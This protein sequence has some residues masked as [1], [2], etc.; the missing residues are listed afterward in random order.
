[1]PLCC[2]ISRIHSTTPAISAAMA[3]C[4]RTSSWINITGLRL[5]IR[6]NISLLKKKIN[7]IWKAGIGYTFFV[8]WS[9]SFETFI[10]IKDKDKKTI[11][12]NH[13]YK[14]T[15]LIQLDAY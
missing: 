13:W 11:Y 9:N 14:N 2:G 5:I 12:T 8:E 7:Q 1:M 10:D 4:R 15:D 6:F 3:E